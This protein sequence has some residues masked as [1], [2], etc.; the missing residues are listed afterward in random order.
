MDKLISTMSDAINNS[1][2]LFVQQIMNKYSIP[3]GE[4]TNILS[5]WKGSKSSPQSEEKLSSEIILKSSVS[6]LKALCRKYSLKVTGKKE[7]LIQRLVD[8]MNNGCE[9]VSGSGSKSKSG[10][11]KKSSKKNV[12]SKIQTAIKEKIPVIQ[13]RRNQ[14]GNYEHKETGFVFSKIDKNVIGKQN[15]S[16]VLDELTEDDIELC[17]K[18]K[19]KYVIPSNLNKKSIKDTIVDEISDDPDDDDEDDLDDLDDLSEEEYFSD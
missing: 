7:I 1:I 9:S 10:S 8:F 13:I 4:K 12:E 3:S 19:F 5:L 2:D 14:F 11:K 16:G 17:N 15:D 6:G 18:Y